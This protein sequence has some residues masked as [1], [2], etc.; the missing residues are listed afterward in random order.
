MLRRR[1]LAALLTLPALPARAAWPDKPIRIVSPYPPGGGTDVTARL[2]SGPLAA[3]FTRGVVVENRPGA[4]G[5]IGAGEVA[6]AA[7]DG[8]TL[9][10]DALGHAVNPA[11]LRGLPFDYA[12][13]FTPLSQ[14]TRLPQIMIAPLSGPSSLAAFVMAARAKPGGFTYGSSGNGTGAQ[15][16]AVLFTRA[17]GLQMEHAPYRGGSTAM[18]AVLAGEVSFTFATVNTA[19]QLVREGQLRGYAVVGDRRLAALPKVPTLTEAGYPGCDLY[20]WNGLFAPAGTPKLVIDTLYGAFSQA[21]RDRAVID[22]FA[23]LGAEPLGTAPSAFAAFVA[24]QRAT[25]AELVR[26]AGIEA[27]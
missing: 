20:E 17:A 11:L 22:R 3:R 5:S 13:A 1:A 25:M 23:E 12:T 8:Y 15:L 21:L 19:A 14:L 2:L 26:E 16:A 6:R 10:I 4:G 7:P 18:Q 27:S 9:L 24:A